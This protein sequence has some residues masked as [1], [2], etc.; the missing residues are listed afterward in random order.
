MDT[1]AG[2][3]IAELARTDGDQSMA[4]MT[5]YARLRAA[6]EGR[7]LAFE[8]RESKTERLAADMA[9]RELWLNSLAKQR[10]TANVTITPLYN[11]DS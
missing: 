3:I 5:Q 1:D 11:Y 7:L 8:S 2:T 6:V 4:R 10:N 9:F